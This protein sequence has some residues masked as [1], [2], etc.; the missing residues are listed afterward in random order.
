MEEGSILPFVFTH[1]LVNAPVAIG[2]FFIPLRCLYSY[3]A[4][5]HVRQILMIL[6]VEQSVTLFECSNKKTVE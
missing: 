2:A 6:S 5:W 4:K 1:A 3:H